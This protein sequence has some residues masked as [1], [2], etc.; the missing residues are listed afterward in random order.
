MNFTCGK[1]KEDLTLTT[2]ATGH[3]EQ[4]ER[5]RQQDNANKGMG[6]MPETS[7]ILAMRERKGLNLRLRRLATE[8]NNS[9]AAKQEA[10]TSQ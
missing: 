5:S 1:N 3:I 8:D 10:L 9:E 2:K 4:Q 7:H 6:R